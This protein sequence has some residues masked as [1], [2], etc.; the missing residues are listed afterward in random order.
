MNGMY[1]NIQKSEQS[2][3]VFAGEPSSLI[4]L[5]LHLICTKKQKEEMSDTNGTKSHVMEPAIP[6]NGHTT[7]NKAPE[8]SYVLNDGPQIFPQCFSITIDH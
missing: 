4:S 8:L 6:G 5:L 7:Y 1:S 3:V 2:T